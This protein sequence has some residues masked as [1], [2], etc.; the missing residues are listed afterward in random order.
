MSTDTE[1][2]LS[3]G[4][5]RLATAVARL[6]DHETRLWGVVVATCLADIVLTTYGLRLGLAEGNPLAAALVGRIGAVP[7]L[8]LLKTGAVGVA[9]TGWAVVPDDYRALIPAGI[10]LPW[11]V[12]S[13]ANAVTIGLELA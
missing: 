8:A 6:T 3:V 10:A 12:A 5:P 4:G 2:T 11:V 7:A 13:A 1:Q 9:V